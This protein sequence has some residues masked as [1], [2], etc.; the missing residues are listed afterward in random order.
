MMTD[1]KQ[2]MDDYGED[3]RVPS[4]GWATIIFVPTGTLP[5]APSPTIQ[6]MFIKVD[7]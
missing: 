6:T 1:M 3:Y 5:S 4:G 2:K 7:P